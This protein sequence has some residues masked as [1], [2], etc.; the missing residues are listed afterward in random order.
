MGILVGLLSDPAWADVG[1]E[2]LYTL[3][4]HGV[5]TV[6]PHSVVKAMVSNDVVL[7]R[8]CCVIGGVS[9]VDYTSVSPTI[10]TP[11]LEYPAKLDAWFDGEFHQKTIST[12]LP[13]PSGFTVVD[14]HLHGAVPRWDFNS[15]LLVPYCARL[16][17]S[18]VVEIVQVC[19]TLKLTG[20]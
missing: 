16:F 17:N 7:F 1:V 8:G 3:T 12:R 4:C 14:G 15:S 18:S 13:L 20:D 9:E 19:C 5:P 2:Q 11:E 10:T 6:N